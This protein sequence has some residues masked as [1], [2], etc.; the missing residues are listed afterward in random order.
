[1][2]K[3]KQLKFNIVDVI[4][5]LAVLAG[6]AFFALRFF[7]PGLSASSGGQNEEEYIITYFVSDSA[8]FIVDHLRVGSA[9]TDNSIKYDLGTLVDFEVGPAQISSTAEDGHQ[10]I[11]TR[12]GYSSVYLMGR[13]TASDNG[14]GVTVDGMNLTIGDS[15][16]VRAQE[17]KFWVVVYDIQKLSDSPYAD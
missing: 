17:A 6:V 9:L 4:F 5:L 7:G 11:T 1:M 3:Q 2:D 14:F 12:E 10:V 15:T 8:D 13:A 16:V